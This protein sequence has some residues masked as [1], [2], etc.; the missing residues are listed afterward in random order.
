MESPPSA[1]GRPESLPAVVLG[2]GYAGLTVAQELHRR[3]RGKVPVVLIDRNPVHVLRTE[4]YEVGKLASTGDATDAWVVPLAG[5]L[6]GTSVAFRQGTVQ[7]IDLAGTTITL[8]TGEVRFRSLAICLGSV[9]AYYGV[10]GAAEHT[11]QV[12]RLSGAK[13]LAAAILQIEKASTSL[14][15][16][17][18]PRI[19]IVG[20]GSTG[21]E[22]AAEIA[23]TDWRAIADPHARRPNVFLLTG[24][25][26]FLAGFPP[27]L[28]ER[29][30]RVLARSGVELV[31]GL[32]VTRVEPGRVTLADG[33]VFACD[34]AVWCAG[35]EAPPVVRQLPV[36][37]GRAGRVAVEATLE[38]PGHS[39]VF[40]VGDVVELQD[41]RTGMPVPSTAQ[42]ALAEA[43]TAARNLLA[44]WKG[45]S[46][47]P[48]EYR[49]RGVVVALGLGQ[50][51]GSVRK[52][53]IWGSP[54]AL[55]KR[56][57]QR[58]YAHSIERGEP[59][60]LI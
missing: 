3:S 30:E 35:L 16:E 49:E 21:T 50:A 7:S 37:H 43:R 55:L 27:A 6:D 8:D 59:P 39:G 53:P 56:I 58:D 29:A 31:R 15:G 4:L 13:R 51:A 60:T 9:A 26:P 42:A 48:F 46:Q 20:G 36:P 25:L 24:S 1:P 5:V 17:R 23:T 52:V 19:L 41:P 34:A 12:Y 14:P 32:N 45:K 10:P 2:A 47:V 44:R 57:V 33:S 11:H 38:I 18:R 22:L 28:V 40:A 54:A